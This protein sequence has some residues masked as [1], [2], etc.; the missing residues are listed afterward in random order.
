MDFLKNNWAK[1]CIVAIALTAVVLL[2]IPIFL[3]SQIELFATFQTLGLIT[4]F[5]GIAIVACLKMCDDK[6]VYAK[7]VLLGSSILVLTFMSIGLGG[8]NSDMEKAQGA[9]GNAFAIFR[10]V[11]GDIEAGQERLAEGEAQRDGLVT[12]NAGLT[13]AGTGIIAQLTTAASAMANPDLSPNVVLVRNLAVTMTPVING[14]PAMNDAERAAAIAQITTLQGGLVQANLGD[15]TVAQAPV[16]LN[17]MITL[18]NQQLAEGAAQLPEDIDAT[19]Q[20]A[21]AGAY[22]VLFVYISM[23]LALG[24]VPLVKSVKKSFFSKDE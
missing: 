6:K 7:Y 18:A 14:N 16:A 1:L 8:F 23:M 21:N 13:T 15:L 20:D 9:L 5:V 2:I 12:M 4:F 22:M 11:E 24:L 17:V 19:K 3:A 10:S